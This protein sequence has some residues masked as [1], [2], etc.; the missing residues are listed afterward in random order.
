M[1]AAEFEQKRS[2]QRDWPKQTDC[3][4]LD[5]VFEA[6]NARGVLALQN[7]GFTLSDGYTE[8]AEALADVDEGEFFGCCFF[9]EQ[10]VDRAMNGGGIDFAFSDLNEPG[11]RTREVG[12][13]VVTA[14]R[15]AGFSVEWT[16][17]P[18]TRVHVAD[19]RWQK[20]S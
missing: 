4:R 14:L 19:F 10:D 9:H 17:D 6:L 3:D 5:R 16:G 7:A 1:I 18:E 2:A 8:V 20:R 11:E 12:E 15:E 13:L